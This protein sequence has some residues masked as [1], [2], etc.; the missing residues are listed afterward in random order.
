MGDAEDKAQR[1]SFWYREELLDIIRGRWKEVNPVHCPS[2]ARPITDFPK[3]NGSR[4][5]DLSLRQQRMT[6]HMLKALKTDLTRI[7]L[8]LVQCCPEETTVKSSCGKFIVAPNTV[9]NLVVEVTNTGRMSIEPGFLLHINH[10]SASTLAMMLDLSTS[11][12]E[13]VLLQGSLSDIVLGR[14][15][16]GQSQVVE[17]PLCFLSAGHFEIAVEAWRLSIVGEKQRTGVT[18]LW[19][20]VKEDDSLRTPFSDLR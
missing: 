3:A 1:E 5:G 13:H 19:A 17:V 2:S 4:N 8:S 15:E 18:R 10:T 12:E 14:L 7:N 11:S 6:M 20:I 9:V 16:S